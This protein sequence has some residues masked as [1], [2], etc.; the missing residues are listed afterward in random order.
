[1]Y[2]LSQIWQ[3]FSR[4][5]SVVEENQLC[6]GDFQATSHRASGS[7][8]IAEGRRCASLRLPS[9][10]S[11]Y[12]IDIRIFATVGWLLRWGRFADVDFIDAPTTTTLTAMSAL[13][14][15]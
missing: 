4:Q 15:G 5:R 9:N 11:K 12:F 8:L 6:L 10:R 7:A 14:P 13:D 2:V 3:E 1:L